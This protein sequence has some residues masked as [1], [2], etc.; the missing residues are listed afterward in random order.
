MVYLLSKGK[1]CTGI[2]VMGIPGVTEEKKFARKF[3]KE[4]ATRYQNK[5]KEKLDIEEIDQVAPAI[6][7]T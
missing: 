3:T 5:V 6:A 4:E 7:A 2:A 1:Y